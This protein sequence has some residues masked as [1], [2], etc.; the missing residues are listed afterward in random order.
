[1]DSDSRQAKGT[2]I[3]L[4]RAPHGAADLE[5]VRPAT[6]I[7][8]TGQH[9]CAEHASFHAGCA[10]C[11][12][13]CANFLPYPVKPGKAVSR[14]FGFTDDLTEAKLREISPKVS[15]LYADEREFSLSLGVVR[16]LVRLIWP[17]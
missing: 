15:N 2:L 11:Q 8:D 17:F 6:V 7:E 13:A 12:Q 9:H 4:R 3:R 5:V 10:T 14:S 16:F 1:M